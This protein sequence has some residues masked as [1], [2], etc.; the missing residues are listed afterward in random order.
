MKLIHQDAALLVVYKPPGLKV[1]R[2]DPAEAASLADLVSERH[3]QGRVVFPVHRL[4][5]VT[6]GLV[7][8]AKD[9][10]TANLLQKKFASGEIAKTYV[11]IVHGRFP[12]AHQRISRP[13]KHPK[14]KELQRA[15]TDVT[16][17]EV[18]R[19][20]EAEYTVLRVDPE[21]GRFHQIRK[22][23]DGEGFPIVGDPLYGKGRKRAG[24]S[25]VKASSSSSTAPAPTA[26]AVDSP[27]GPK[28]T[29]PFG[30]GLALAAVALEFTH[31]VSRKPLRFETFP[32][33]QFGQWIRRAFR[34]SPA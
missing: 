23:L 34:K 17:L 5:A 30:D 26:P 2:D 1:Y 24:A 12:N 22:H 11:A 4:D 7:V 25:S 16:V 28:K 27:R 14:T 8:F 29:S 9:P 3:F 32:D 31:P 13:L 6:S 20:G 10:K 19:E 18:R 15:L 21:T 33:G